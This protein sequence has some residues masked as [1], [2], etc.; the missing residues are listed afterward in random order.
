MACGTP[1]S[2]GKGPARPGLHISKVS[3]ICLIMENRWSQ[4]SCIG[5]HEHVP[6]HLFCDSSGECQLARPKANKGRGIADCEQHEVGA[7][8]HFEEFADETYITGSKP[9]LSLLEDSSIADQEL[10]AGGIDKD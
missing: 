2:E 8:Q 9:G 10:K 3:A 7:A 6:S 5:R 1:A 4:K